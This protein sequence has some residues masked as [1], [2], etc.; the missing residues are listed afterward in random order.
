MEIVNKIRIK[1]IAQKAGVSEGTVDRVLHNRGEVSEKSR[2]AV[3][4]AIDELHYRPNVYARSLATKK[5]FRFV[6]F[7]PEHTQ[8]DYWEKVED[9]IKMAASELAD[10]NVA[11][12]PLY[13]NQYNH[14][15]YAE[16][17]RQILELQPDG[18]VI[19]PTFSDE[20]HALIAELK[21]KNIPYSF[22]DSLIDDHDF[23]SYYGQHSFHS[24]YIAAKL[25]LENLPLY[26]PVLLVRA[27]REGGVI[28]NQTQERYK[29]F[30]DYVNRQ[31][32]NDKY[33][34]TPLV[35][36]DGQSEQNEQVFLEA[37]RQNNIKAVITFNSKV[38]RIAHYLDKDH[39]EGIRL[40]GY[41]LLDKNVYFLKK[42]IIHSL[43]AQRPEKQAYLVLKDLC[44]NIIFKQ[45]TEQ[46]N[47]IPIDILIKENIDYYMNFE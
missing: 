3:Q 41:D 24:G 31:N 19:V 2:Q 29:G 26:S 12:T 18:V 7:L 45:E 42:G 21:A 10:F 43:I 4:K 11:V 17:S 36:E 33:T 38:Y 9:G 23:L 8:G 15:S 6:F 20:A 13:Y 35:L 28:S 14:S 32:L 34:F 37:I 27:K 40:I 5:H 39:V 22:I 47:Y 16:K 30:I 46:V 25:L 1:D 44:K